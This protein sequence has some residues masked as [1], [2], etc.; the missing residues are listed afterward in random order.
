MYTYF[1]T[2]KRVVVLNNIETECDVISTIVYSTIDVP[3]KN[4]YSTDENICVG[5]AYFPNE[6]VKFVEVESVPSKEDVQPSQL[7][8]IEANTASLKADIEQSAIDIYT[9][10]LMESGLL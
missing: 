7:D 4:H 9:L 2:E 10:E 3:P 1:A 6:E 8:R 5:L